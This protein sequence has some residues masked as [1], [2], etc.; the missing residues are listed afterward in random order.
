MVLPL[1]YIHIFY[2]FLN[3]LPNFRERD[4]TKIVLHAGYLNCN[5]GHRFESW[6]IE[7]FACQLGRAK[8]SFKSTFDLMYAYAHA[9]LDEETI[10]FTSFSSGDEL[11]GFIL[12]LYGLKGPP[13]FFSKQM[14]SFFRKLIGQGYTLVYIS[15]ILLLAHTKTHML[16]LVEQLPQNC[17]YNNLKS[18]AEKSFFILFT[19][20]FL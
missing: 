16:D 4:T 3:P 11:Y 18:A 7:T 6:R 12:N 10:T 8:K 19:V 20:K 14:C 17:S 13:N 15:D 5:T 1:Q 9:P 2:S